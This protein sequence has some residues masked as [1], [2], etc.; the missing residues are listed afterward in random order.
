VSH[1]AI[2]LAV[3]S[4]M[5]TAYFRCWRSDVVALAASL[6]D[7]SFYAILPAWRIWEHGRFTFDGIHAAYGFQPMWEI[8]LVALAGAS[9]SK[10]LFLRLAL[11]FSY[12]L[13][14]AAALVA[15]DLVRTLTRGS[16][17]SSAAGAITTCLVLLNAQLQCV[18]TG[19]K[20]RPSICFCWR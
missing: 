3:T 7:D 2:A 15:G 12:L 8:V 18:A 13:I 14:V 19:G 16:R 4:T 9:S 6:A 11:F 20:R 1:L 10:E 17:T 5:A